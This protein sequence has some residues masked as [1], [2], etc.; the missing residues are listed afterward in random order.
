MHH[1][2]NKTQVQK[3]LPDVERRV[4]QLHFVILGLLNSAQLLE[5]ALSNVAGDKRW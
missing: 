5:V 4:K 2:I 1:S 3:G